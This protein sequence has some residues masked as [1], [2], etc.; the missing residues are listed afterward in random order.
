MEQRPQLKNALVRL[1]GCLA[2]GG[3]GMLFIMSVLIGFG[4]STV[5]GREA[6]YICL[7]LQTCNLA[8]VFSR[9]QT[10]LHTGLAPTPSKK[11]QLLRRL[12]GGLWIV[13][14]LLLLLSLAL[15]LFRLPMANFWVKLTCYCGIV[16][17]MAGWVG[18]LAAYQRLYH[19][20]LALSEAPNSL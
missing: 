13:G 12:C 5:V 6:L 16:M 15:I 7:L 3:A 2:L 17:A 8:A 4:V 14:A 20:A 18:S 10:L 9:G 11:M 19:S 1:T